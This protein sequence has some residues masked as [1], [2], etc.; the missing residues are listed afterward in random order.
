[1]TLADVKKDKGDYLRLEGTPPDRFDGNCERM[2]RFLTQFKRFML[3][4]DGATISH[5]PI[6]RCAY[7]LSLIEGSKVEGWTDCSYK[8][9]DK[10]QNNRASIPFGMT[11][12]EVLK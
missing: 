12:W 2:L 5:N 11:A 1:M 9:L 3:M 10:V 6:K 8:W 7:F 4:N